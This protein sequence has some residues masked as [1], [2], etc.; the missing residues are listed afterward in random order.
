MMNQKYHALPILILLSSLLV[1]SLPTVSQSETASTQPAWRS[2]AAASSRMERIRNEAKVVGPDL[3]VAENSVRSLEFTSHG[4]RYIPKQRAELQP[5]L[6]FHFQLKAIRSGQEF[7]LDEADR[8]STR[9]VTAGNEIAYPRGRGITEVYQALDSGVEQLFVLEQNLHPAGESLFITGE[10]MTGLTPESPT[11]RTSRG[12]I[13]Y[14]GDNP[15]VRYG[16]AT[17]IDALG[18]Q[19]RAELE[20][21]GDQLSIILDS[22]WLR[23]A[24]YP[25]IVDPFIGPLAQVAAAGPHRWYPAMASDTRQNR[26]LVVWEQP[27]EDDFEIMGQLI[28]ADGKPSA[29]HPD[30]FSVSLNP[31]GRDFSPAVTYDPT[32]QRFL[33]VWEEQ[34]QAILGSGTFDYTIRGRFVGGPDGCAMVTPTGQPLQIS[35]AGGLV[36][37]APDVAVGVVSDVASYFLI[38]FLQASAEAEEATVSGQRLN[39]DGSRCGDAV[40][41]GGPSG[42]ETRFHPSVAFGE[43]GVAEFFSVVYQSSDRLLQVAK[44]T[45]TCGS[46]VQNQVVLDVVADPPSDERAATDVRPTIAYSRL[47]RR[48]L[49]NWIDYS[50]SFG[51]VLLWSEL[52][53]SSLSSQSRFKT[54]LGQFRYVRGLSVTSTTQAPDF[55]VT[56]AV[57]RSRFGGFDIFLFHLQYRFDFFNASFR[58][59][60]LPGGDLND[61]YPVVGSSP[62]RDDYFVVWQRELP[63]DASDIVGQSYVP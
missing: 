6:S 50:P 13:F 46:L 41:I 45:P 60:T 54:L 14:A 2:V 62:V 23:Q 39:Q 16:A 1:P 19:W 26:H 51:A 18:R 32:S 57:G 47:G 63:D 7:Y 31:A 33:V 40:L 56:L 52:S 48:W 11:L 42:L 20:L 36:E 29:C 58:R 43:A 22:A 55:V 21:D 17:A 12:I 10:V 4:L 34:S 9:P 53:A 30:P 44:L 8:N 38:V 49:I 25:V 5:D 59:E 24:A 15:I 3:I 61:W 28:D 35:D 27:V 37:R